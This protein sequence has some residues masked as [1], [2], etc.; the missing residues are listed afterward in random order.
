M[1]AASLAASL[2]ALP[3]ML[4]PLRGM[5]PSRPV[6]IIGLGVMPPISLGLMP[7]L[8]LSAGSIKIG[9]GE[10]AQNGDAERRD[11]AATWM[12]ARIG[13]G[14]R[15]AVKASVVHRI[16]LGVLSRRPS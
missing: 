3:A 1:L 10:C 6:W 14:L 7:R 16:P 13:Q 12:T 8:S 2:A 11:D 15:Q 5:Q 4:L 9:S